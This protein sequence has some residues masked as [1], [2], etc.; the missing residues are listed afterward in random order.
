MY[1]DDTPLDEVPVAL[2]L[3]VLLH[4]VSATMPRMASRAPIGPDRA[5]RGRCPPDLSFILRPRDLPGDNSRQDAT[6]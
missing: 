2:P 4:A 5:G 3:L 6:T 1:A